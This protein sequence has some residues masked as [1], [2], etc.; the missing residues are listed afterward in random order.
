VKKLKIAILDAATLGGDIDLSAFK[1]YGEVEIYEYT[2]AR[3]V[4]SRSAG[5]DILITNK[6]PVGKDTIDSSPC[7]KLICVAATG[8]NNIDIK[9]CREKGVAVAN[10]AG[11][12]TSSV[13]QHTFSMALYLIGSTRYYDDFVRNG[14]YS[15]SQIF[16]HTGRPFNEICSMKWGVIGLGAIGSGVAKVAS[17]FGAAVSYYSTSGK[18]QSREYKSEGL[19]ELLKTSDI[20]SIHAPLNEKTKDLIRFQQLSMMKPTA[21]IL[22]L[23]RGGIINE[24]DLVRALDEKKIRAA[25][26]DVMESE[27]PSPESRLFKVADLERLLITPH[28]AWTSV[29]ARKRLV[30]EIALNIDFFL[31]GECRNRLDLK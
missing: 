21:I 9:Y 7:L 23:G 1:K 12:S 31:N 3:D 5:R 11:Y 15:K 4:L 18:N 27:P 20:I 16:S 28:I 8:A 29:E 22:N 6:V 13:V 14:E 25:G 17:A 2:A 26:L 30:H 10:V 24:A 19:E